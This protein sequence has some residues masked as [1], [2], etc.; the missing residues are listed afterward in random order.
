[1]HVLHK[2]LVLKMLSGL[3]GVLALT[4]YNTVELQIP[5]VKIYQFI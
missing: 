2:K 5:R 1:M 3:T 4:L